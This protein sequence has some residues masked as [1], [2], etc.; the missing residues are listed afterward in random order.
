MRHGHLSDLN[1]W[2]SRPPSTHTH[3]TSKSNMWWFNVQMIWCVSKIHNHLL[4]FFFL[5]S[6]SLRLPGYPCMWNDTCELSTWIVKWTLNDG[7][8]HLPKL[9]CKQNGHLKHRIHSSDRAIRIHWIPFRN[10]CVLLAYCTLRQPNDSDTRIFKAGFLLSVVHC[11]SNL[12]KLLNAQSSF[13]ICFFF[14]WATKRILNW[15]V[16]S[17][18]KSK[19]LLTIIIYPLFVMSWIRWTTQNNLNRIN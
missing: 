11:C 17:C 13:F 4:Q 10:P 15:V 3:T 12:Q 9:K 16:F 1:E 8:L 7:L 14:F 2:P 5:L 18:W 19:L 6:F